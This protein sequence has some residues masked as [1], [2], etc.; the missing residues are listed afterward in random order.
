MVANEPITDD[1]LSKALYKLMLEAKGKFSDNKEFILIPND[2]PF[3][4]AQT[5]FRNT[6]KTTNGKEYFMVLHEVPENQI[7]DYLQ[8]RKEFFNSYNI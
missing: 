4:R 8:M 5:I 6:L 1:S 7:E 3:E 2:F